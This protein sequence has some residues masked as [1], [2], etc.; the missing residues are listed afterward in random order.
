MVSVLSP[1]DQLE[2]EKFFRELISMRDLQKRFFKGDRSVV[3]RAKKTEAE[4][5][6]GIAKLTERLHIRPPEEPKKPDQGSLD[7]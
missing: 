4:V 2:I 3:A 5:D 7:W 6:R 1:Q